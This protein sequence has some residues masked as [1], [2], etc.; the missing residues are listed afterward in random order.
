MLCQVWAATARDANCYIAVISGSPSLL[1]RRPN[2]DACQ[3]VFRVRVRLQARA[4]V[5]SR[6]PAFH[7][8]SAHP[9]DLPPPEAPGSIPHILLSRLRISALMRV[10][11]MISISRDLLVIPTLLLGDA[12]R[13]MDSSLPGPW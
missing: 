4:R 12:K 7:P 2:T 6:G 11:M 8:A 13:F 9:S 10:L 5:P 3:R 1:K